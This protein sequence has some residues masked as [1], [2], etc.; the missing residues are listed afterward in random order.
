[1]DEFGQEIRALYFLE[2]E[3]Q[4]EV[5][6]HQ[7]LSLSGLW[8]TL[9]RLT[10]VYIVQKLDPLPKGAELLQNQRLIRLEYFL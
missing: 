6:V 4:L 1:M 8:S 3:N 7:A 9:D 10:H 2:I 5:R